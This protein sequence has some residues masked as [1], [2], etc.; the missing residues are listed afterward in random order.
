[1]MQCIA[2]AL[3]VAVR[4]AGG[5]PGDAL[6]PLMQLPGVDGEVIKRL[7]KH[8]IGSLAGEKGGAGEGRWATS[9][10]QE[11]ALAAATLTAPAHTHIHTDG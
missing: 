1:M 7:R 8:R 2:Q 3:T 5:R 6:A 10:W 9:A 4:K 11:G